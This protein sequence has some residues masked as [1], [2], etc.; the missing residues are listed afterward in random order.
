MGTLGGL[1]S[2]AYGLNNRGQVVG[3]S[4]MADYAVH[5][6]LWDADTGM[7]D[8]GTIADYWGREA[9]AINTAGQV[10][11]VVYDD[12]GG[13]MRP[14]LYADGVMHD[15]NDLIPAGSGWVLRNASAINNAGMIVGNGKLNEAGRA[16]MLV[17]LK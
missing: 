3:F 16:F 8:I 17:P 4:E 10:I 2:D 9:L 7:T 13:N 12:Q 15:L 6:F 5:A 14:F 11:G 1:N